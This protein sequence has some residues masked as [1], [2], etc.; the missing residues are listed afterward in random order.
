MPKH[1]NVQR[2]ISVYD[3]LIHAELAAQIT[4]PVEEYY[5]ARLEQLYMAMAQAQRNT[6]PLELRWNV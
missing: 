5:G 6:W 3:A 4:H 2:R 1:M